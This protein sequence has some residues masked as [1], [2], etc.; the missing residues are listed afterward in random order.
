MIIEN[1]YRSGIIAAI[2]RFAMR[3]MKHNYKR[4]PHEPKEH[5]NA[6]VRTGDMRFDVRMHDGRQVHDTRHE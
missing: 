3:L 4:P 5:R 2:P 1:D 6:R